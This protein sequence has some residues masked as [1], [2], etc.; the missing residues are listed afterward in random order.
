MPFVLYAAQHPELAR[1]PNTWQLKYTDDAKGLLYILQ[2]YKM[3][4]KT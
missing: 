4:N 1:L 3:L 2:L